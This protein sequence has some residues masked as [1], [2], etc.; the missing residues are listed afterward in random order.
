VEKE[1]NKIKNGGKMARI[2]NK[3]HEEIKEIRKERIKNG[4]DPELST[5]SKITNLITRHSLWKDI[6]KGVINIEDEEVKKYG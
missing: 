1:V 4:K 5:T 2:G 6:K 3:F